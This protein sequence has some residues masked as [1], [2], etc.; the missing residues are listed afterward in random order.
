MS[1]EGGD[2]GETRHVKISW[3]WMNSERR[4]GD[5]KT[6]TNYTAWVSGLCVGFFFTRLRINSS[7][8]PTRFRER[9]P[10]TAGQILQLIIQIKD[11]V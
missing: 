9:L 10:N 7:K 2:E 6:P 5:G 3:E 11:P 8:D 4:R 1:E